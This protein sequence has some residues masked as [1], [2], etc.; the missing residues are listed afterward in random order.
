MLPVPS[1]DFPEQAPFPDD[2]Q[3]SSQNQRRETQEYETSGKSKKKGKSG[4]KGKVK[5]A[6]ATAKPPPEDLYACF[7][8]GVPCSR[9][10]SLTW[11]Y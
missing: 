9:C 7:S 2:S 1:D 5:G 4:S 10:R 8:A 6:K 3:P 11:A